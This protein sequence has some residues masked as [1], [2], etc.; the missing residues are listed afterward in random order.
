MDVSDVLRDRMQEPPGLQRMAVVSA[1]VHVAVAVAVLLGPGLLLPRQQAPAPVMTISLGAGTPGPQ[2][3][4]MTSMGGRAVQAETP[5]DI[6]R[7]PPPTPPAPKTPQMTEPVKGRAP[8]RTTKPPVT[9]APEGATGRTPSKGAETAAG[10]ANVETN[11]RGQGFGL[12]T[13][14]GLGGG[15]VTLDVANFCCAWYLTQM[16]QRIHEHWDPRAETPAQVIVAFTI[17]R[18][19]LLTDIQLERSS[20]YSAL[21]IAAQRSLATTR[22]L[23]PLPAEFPNPT[24]RVH[25]T[26]QYTR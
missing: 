20:G 3:G 7:P 5:P 16:N 8:A 10:S 2:S 9:Q 24:L 12:S 14:G 13:S 21:D 6:K 25:L 22:Q 1:I 26:F 11:V 17:Q 18:N 15:G 4:G 19:G 23:T